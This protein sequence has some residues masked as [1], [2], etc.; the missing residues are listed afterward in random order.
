MGLSSAGPSTGVF[1][2]GAASCA[3][4][5]PESGVGLRGNAGRRQH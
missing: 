5:L 4:A 1:G 3:G 2:N